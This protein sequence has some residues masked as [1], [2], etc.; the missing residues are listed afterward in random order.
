MIDLDAVE[1]VLFVPGHRAKEWEQQ[2]RGANPDLIIWDLEDSVP[3]DEKDN[4]REQVVEVATE[5]DGVRVNGG[6]TRWYRD[7][8]LQTRGSGLWMIPKCETVVGIPTGKKVVALVE[9]PLGV[10]NL[11][12]LSRGPW[13]AL[14]L[15]VSDLSAS[16]GE[17]YARWD[18]PVIQQALCHTLLTSRAMGVPCW[19]GPCTTTDPAGR[20]VV[21]KQHARNM[22]MM[23]HHTV[24]CIHPDQIPP[25]REAFEDRRTAWQTFRHALG[26]PSPD[27]PHL[28]GGWQ[29]MSPAN[30]RTALSMISAG[31]KSS[32][33]PFD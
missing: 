9:T 28:L 24:V 11:P 22:L 19:A 14:S 29:V 26:T 2:A 1:V 12:E 18:H 20:K 25:T 31:S 27:R 7:D 15:G 17:P 5:L 4:A 6:T 8:L 3:N 13:L 32:E 16:L 10:L 30:V 23:G 33:T 21:A